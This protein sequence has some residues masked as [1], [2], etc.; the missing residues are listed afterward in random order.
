MK[1]VY[2]IL[3]FV[4]MANH[5]FSQ[6]MPAADKFSTSAGSLEIRFIGHGSLMFSVNNMTIYVDPVR[7][8][9]SY[10]GL[11]K[12]DLIL[13]THEHGDHLDADLI[14]TLQKDGTTIFSSAK[15]AESLKTAK[16]MHPGDEN[17]VNGI[18]VKAV[19]AYNIKNERAPGQPFHPKGVGNGYILTIG[20]KKIYVAGDTENIPEMAELKNIYI[21]FLPMNL[22]YTMTPNMVVEAA[23]TIKP[24]ILY[25][26]HYGQTNTA[27]LVSLLKNSG[28]EVR[29]R[30]L[31]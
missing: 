21:A 27:E 11:P 3:T 29:I 6:D 30:D 16:V 7:S 28:I 18:G 26:Y 9:G 12:A 25:P 14:K 13:I 23:M 24:S 1:K 10:Q 2:L 15:A 31:K 8:S 22:P 20:D 4:M 5:M 17:T 19:F